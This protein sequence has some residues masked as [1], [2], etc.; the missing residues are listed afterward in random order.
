[1]LQMPEAQRL[2]ATLPIGLHVIGEDRVHQQ[3]RVPEDIM[4]A[5]GLLEV[6]EL[7][8]PANEEGRWEP[9]AGEMGEEHIVRDE[10]GHSHD[11]PSCGGIEDIAEAAE[12]RDPVRLHT[13]P[14]EPFE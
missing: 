4:E 1:M 9:P 12:I 14:S 2:E 3:R 10:P 13:E 11:L 5:V 8:W 7:I 6:I